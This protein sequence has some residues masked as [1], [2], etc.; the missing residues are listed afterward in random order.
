MHLFIW[1]SPQTTQGGT[2][3]ILLSTY[4]YIIRRFLHNVRLR[5]KRAVCPICFSAVDRSKSSFFSGRGHGLLLV[6]YS[7]GKW[8]LL[9]FL[10]VECH[11][12]IPFPCVFL[13]HIFISF[14]HLATW[15]FIFPARP[16]TWIDWCGCAGWGGW[17]GG[18]YLPTYLPTW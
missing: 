18:R 15:Y 10:V 6:S 14:L 2:Y 13:F 5:V 17:L 4:T 9:I 8:C 11:P 3:I 16:Y 12:S 1:L 7:F